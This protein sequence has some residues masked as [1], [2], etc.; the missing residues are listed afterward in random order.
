RRWR[1]SGATWRRDRPGEAGGGRPAR[2]PRPARRAAQPAPPAPAAEAGP[3]RRLSDRRRC[4]QPGMQRQRRRP[5]R[6]AGAWWAGYV[7]TATRGR[8]TNFG[9]PWFKGDVIPFFELKFDL[10]PLH[11]QGFGLFVLAGCFG[12]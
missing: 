8:I 7:L 5:A 4:R 10:G 12:G 2:E 11:L 6:S 1:G 9:A 3:W